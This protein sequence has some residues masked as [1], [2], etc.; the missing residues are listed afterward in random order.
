MILECLCRGGV[1]WGRQHHSIFL[2]QRPSPWFYHF[3]NF[4]TFALIKRM[5]FFLPFSPKMSRLSLWHLPK[6]KLLCSSMSSCSPKTTWNGMKSCEK[7]LKDKRMINNTM[8]QPDDWDWTNPISLQQGLLLSH[9]NNWFCSQF[10]N[11][12]QLACGVWGG[13]G[14]VLNV[15]GGHGCQL[16]FNYDFFVLGYDFC[17]PRKH[18]LHPCRGT[19]NHTPEGWQTD[20]KS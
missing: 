6:L 14:G 5:L 18:W 1:F 19:V 11:L 20:P 10:L 4:I 15:G 3:Q 16:W 9:L 8:E 7:L 13:G 2:C 17:W 12:P